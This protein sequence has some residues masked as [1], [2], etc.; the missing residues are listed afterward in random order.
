MNI[1][2][3]KQAIDRYR[4]GEATVR[5]RYAVIAASGLLLA[6]MVAIT[7]GQIMEWTIGTMPHSAHFAARVL[8]WS[9]N[10]IGMRP[11]LLAAF[12]VAGA[13]WFWLRAGHLDRD[14][15]ELSRAARE[16]GDGVPMR[17][18]RVKSGGEL[19]DLAEQLKRVDRRVRESESKGA[20]FAG[21]GDWS[22]LARKPGE[23]ARTDEH[24]A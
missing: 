4:N 7:F 15:R 11:M 23:Y 13:A 19:R 16:L 20:M 2:R 3:I 18:A 1:E 6:G 24:D 12:S 8:R 22:H 14:L 10:H 5:M 21:V 17:P 9:V